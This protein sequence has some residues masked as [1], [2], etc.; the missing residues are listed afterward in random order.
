MSQSQSP[1]QW[2]QQPGAYAQPG[3]QQ[4]S[5]YT[6]QGYYGYGGRPSYH[7]PHRGTTVLVLGILGFVVCFILGA[8]AWSMGNNDLRK[9]NAGI[10]DPSGRDMTNAGRICG[11]IS[12][13]LGIVWLG[14]T[15]VYMAFVL[16]MVAAGGH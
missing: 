13:I 10:M 5:A 14:F 8:V 16:S 15:V 12:T 7:E 11:M 9:I 4:N 3:G 1:G 6:Q 2:D